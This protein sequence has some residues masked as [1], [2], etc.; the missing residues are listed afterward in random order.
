MGDVIAF[1][2]RK[3]GERARGVTLCREG[4]HKWQIWQRKQF[5]VKA[6]KL[7]TVYRCARC[8]ATRVETH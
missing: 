6:G 7:V 3:P 8:E 1:R 5:D 4:F 2:K